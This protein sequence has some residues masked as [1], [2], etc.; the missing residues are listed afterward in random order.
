MLLSQ[1]RAT[2]TLAIEPL[3]DTNCWQLDDE[4][5]NFNLRSWKESKNLLL[6]SESN[7]KAQT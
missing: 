7:N 3:P 4:I 6:K 1:N 5:N 2:K